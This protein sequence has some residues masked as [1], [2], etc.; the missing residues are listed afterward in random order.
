MKAHDP[1]KIRSSIPWR[2][3]VDYPE[4]QVPLLAE[5]PISDTAVE[6]RDAAKKAT[7]EQLYVLPYNHYDPDNSAWWVLNS[8]QKPAYRFGKIIVM[9]DPAVVEPGDRFI[10]LHVEKGV[11]GELAAATF[12]V[13]HGEAMVM[14]ASWRWH[15][16]VRAWR[17]GRFAEQAVAAESVAG[18]PLTVALVAGHQPLPD[19]EH[20]EHRS[21]DNDADV[22]R[23][24]CQAGQLT[25][26]QGIRRKGHL[27]ALAKATSF[28]DIAGAIRSIEDVDFVWIEFLIGLRFELTR[29]SPDDVWS[30][31]GVWD[32]VCRPWQDWL[33]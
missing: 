27:D 6:L 28:A 31:R 1:L 32:R 33:R 20:A 23:F 26:I 5:C 3:V 16:L 12:A 8:N 29:D 7:Q 17:T 9:K 15:E 2:Q 24:V 18:R 4:S 30:A 13:A 22:A 19:K 14:E 21:Q 25:P 11:Q 10:G